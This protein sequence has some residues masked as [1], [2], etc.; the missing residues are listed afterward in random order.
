MVVPSDHSN[1][2]NKITIDFSLAYLVTSSKQIAPCGK[3]FGVGG[4][5]G[6]EGRLGST[7]RPQTTFTYFVSLA[8]VFEV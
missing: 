2:K 6:G 3:L 7:E 5:G 8:I 4:G 1:Y